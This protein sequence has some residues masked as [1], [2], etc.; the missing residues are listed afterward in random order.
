M[1]G[2]RVVTI[3]VVLALLLPWM[4][5]AFAYPRPGETELVSVSTDG[6]QTEGQFEPNFV[7]DI[8]PDGRYVAFDGWSPNLA[9]EHDDGDRARSQVYVRDRDTGVTTLESVNPDGVKADSHSSGGVI[10]PDARHIAFSSLGRNLAPGS[11]NGAHQVYVRDR[12]TGAIDRLSVNGEGEAGAAPG[13]FARADSRA[14]SITP[15]ARFVAFHSRAT[16]LVSA[17]DANGSGRDVFVRDR[18]AGVTERVSV[19]SDGVQHPGESFFPTISDDGRYVGF[20]TLSMQPENAIRF[21]PRESDVHQ[22]RAYVHDRATGETTLV[23]VASDGSPANGYSE[24]DAMSPDGRFIVFS[25]DATNLTPNSVQPQ[26][27]PD[28]RISSEEGGLV[29][30][31]V[32]TW[33]VYVHDRETGVTERV[34]VSSTGKQGN[35]GSSGGRITDD[36]R[37]VTFLSGATDFVDDDT[38][39]RAD[40]FVHDRLTGMTERVSISS[41][42]GQVS[43]D[44][45]APT[46]INADGRFPAFTCSGLGLVPEDTNE[47][48]DA[49]VRDRGPALGV[50]RLDAI[51]SRSSI[52]A[53]GWATFT[54][55][56]LTEASDPIDDASGDAGQQQGA[57]LS[58]A[59]LVYRAEGEGLL[60]R[61]HLADLPGEG[62]PG[63]VYGLRF[64]AGGVSYE[65]RGSAP[66]PDST[67]FGLYRCDPGCVSVA[68]LE[69]SYGDVGRQVWASLPL[70][71]SPAAPGDGLS[72]IGAY[73]GTG[74]PSSG[75]LVTIDDL[76]L[77]DAVVPQMR[78]DLGLA[79]AGT[80]EDGVA[81]DGSADL[82]E[83][84]FSGSLD[85]SSL[86][87]GRYDVWARACLDEVCGAE[88]TAVVIGELPVGEIKDTIL[89]ITVEG[90]G[91]EM[92]LRARL[93][94]LDPPQS[95]IA[96]RAIDFYSDGELI[97]SDETDS[98]GIATIAVQ[99]EHRGANRTYEAIFQGDDFYAPSSDERPGRGGGESDGGETSD[100]Q[101]GSYGEAL[102]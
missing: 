54:G 47:G 68:E 98:D 79:S 81:F 101:S 35:G 94:E 7:T 21:P 85:I 51:P 48:L 50:A 8:S 44:C 60:A 66:T 63:I 95:P 6:R 49:F 57:E 11:N 23:S 33:N 72:E 73:T 5:P 15:D 71:V 99:P 30:R 27:I 18:V 64:E 53:S 84:D 67:D 34:S 10:T 22:V 9:P 26:A 46:Q 31:E 58:K 16:N 38:N 43:G 37:F 74:T 40:I 52:G 4:S 61:W 20:G 83:G 42:G 100:R 17:P 65:I 80:P 25:S 29:C 62:A 24:L 88:S 36:G 86:P 56:S 59:E 92:T 93:G 45:G 96:G 41:D 76:D 3:G 75:A 12:A 82:A 13:T 32:R 28:C 90:Q 87:D 102:R 97:G 77:A 19:D 14:P 91:Q 89:E 69:A 39:G 1:R 78:V 2:A 55:T 70:D